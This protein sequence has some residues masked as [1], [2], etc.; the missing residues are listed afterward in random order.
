MKESSRS[1][2]KEIKRLGEA[3]PPASHQTSETA[4]KRRTVRPHIQTTQLK[5]KY[6][7]Q[8]FYIQQRWAFSTK[9]IVKA[10]NIGEHREFLINELFFLCHD[11][12]EAVY[13]E[14]GRRE[15]GSGINSLA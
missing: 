2:G 3:K 1:P 14:R 13:P 8:E 11:K 12:I 5:K 10:L 15:S 4:Y 6:M 9:S 7:D